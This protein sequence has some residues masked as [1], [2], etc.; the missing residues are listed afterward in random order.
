MT[1]RPCWEPLDGGRLQSTGR[2]LL[3]YAQEHRIMASEILHKP[4]VEMTAEGPGMEI[5]PTSLPIYENFH[6]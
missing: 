5:V 1:S 6:C 3:G 2:Q 4:C